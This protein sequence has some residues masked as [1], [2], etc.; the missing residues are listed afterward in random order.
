MSDVAAGMD[1][2]RKGESS[3]RGFLFEVLRHWKHATNRLSLV[4]MGL[5]SLVRLPSRATQRD[6]G[7]GVWE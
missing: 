1:A 4:K 7:A 3:E 2:E 6:K 5:V